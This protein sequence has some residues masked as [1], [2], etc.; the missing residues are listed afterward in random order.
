MLAALVAR[1]EDMLNMSGNISPDC[2]HRGTCEPSPKIE[3]AHLWCENA[4]KLIDKPWA[5]VKVLQTVY[6]QLQPNRFEDLLLLEP[7]ALF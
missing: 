6:R 7:K 2:R 5:Y 4:T 1:C 3:P